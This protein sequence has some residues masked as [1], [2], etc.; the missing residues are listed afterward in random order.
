M[1]QV[2]TK[3]PARI[4]WPLNLDPNDRESG[5]FTD[6]IKEAVAHGPNFAG[7]YSIAHWGLG[8]GISS[9]AVVDLVTGEVFREMPFVFLDVPWDPESKIPYRGYSFRANS[10]LLIASGCFYKGE[11]QS[12]NDCGWKY[13]KWEQN[14]FVLLS[15]VPG[16]VPSNYRQQKKHQE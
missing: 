13:Y 4:L 9:I 14:R 7:H 5:K 11:S 2:S 1:N 3:K 8:T 12:G 15:A 16:P 10:R 6:S